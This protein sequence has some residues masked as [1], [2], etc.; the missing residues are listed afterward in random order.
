[1]SGDVKHHKFKALA[2]LL[3]ICALRWPAAMFVMFAVM[4]LTTSFPPSLPT[5]PAQCD[6][7]IVTYGII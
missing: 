2:C 3:E 4:L 7:V 5:L 1:M 6:I